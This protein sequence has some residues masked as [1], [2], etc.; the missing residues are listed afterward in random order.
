MW[1]MAKNYGADINTLAEEIYNELKAQ[2]VRE[3]VV[4]IVLRILAQVIGYQSF[5]TEGKA[6]KSDLNALEMTLKNHK[7]LDG[8]VVIP[9]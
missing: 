8:K 2:N 1:D 6:D 5:L 7:H 4:E 3:P 9:L